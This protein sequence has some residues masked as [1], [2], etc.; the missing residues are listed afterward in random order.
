MWKLPW[1]MLER[2]VN[3]HVETAPLLVDLVDINTSIPQDIEH[4][5]YYY[6]VSWAWV[7][8]IPLQCSP[9]ENWPNWLLPF[10]T[11]LILFYIT[12]NVKQSPLGRLTE[13][14]PWDSY[15]K[16]YTRSFIE[17]QSTLNVSMGWNI[18]YNLLFFCHAAWVINL[19]V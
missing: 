5:S 3:S 8:S 12:V 13:L 19:T 9:F 10:V 14:L 11:L 16:L 2:T 6:T 4:W 15:E 7:S 18:L 17:N 1:F